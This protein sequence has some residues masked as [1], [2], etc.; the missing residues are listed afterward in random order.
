MKTPEAGGHMKKTDKRALRDLCIYQVYVRNHTE[1][2]TFVA[3]MD[4]LSR[5]KSMGVDVVYLLPIHP[6]G[7]LKRKGKYGSPYAIK[8]YMAINDELGSTEDFVQLIDAVHKHDMQI[9][10]DIVFNHTAP[11]AVWVKKYPTFYYRNHKGAMANRVGEWT[12]IVD[13]D[14]T[15]APSLQTQLIDVLKHY[16]KLGVDGYR[17]DVPSLLPFDFL[18][19]ARK[20]IDAMNPNTLWLSESVHGHFLKAFR[21]QGFEGLSESELY[22]VFDMAYDYDAHPY[23]EAYLKGEGALSDYVY[24]LQKQEEIYPKDYVKMR[25]LENHDF[26]RIAHFLKN[27][28]KRLFMWHAF[29]YFNR[30]A[31]MI[32]SG[33]ETF[34]SHHPDLFNKDTIDFSQPSYEDLFAHLKKLSTGKLFT[35][36]VYTVEKAHNAECIITTYQDETKTLKGIFNVGMGN[37]RISIDFPDDDYLNHFNGKTIRIENGSFS[38]QNEPVIITMEATI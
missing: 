26:G 18:K 14:F 25:N 22:Q 8:D 17:F 3:L 13:F 33:T 16:T 30:G 32:F 24:W 1:A 35:E 37:G 9:M 2:G 10:M 34:T 12:D 4:D 5:I 6:I 27:D 21:D 23:F 20:A 38:L 31:T 7:V 28:K 19:R 36:G 11:D 29:N 15:K